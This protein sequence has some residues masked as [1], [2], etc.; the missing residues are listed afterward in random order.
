[1]HR[2]HV[3]QLAAAFSLCLSDSIDLSNLA[4]QHFHLDITD[5]LLILDAV[6]KSNGLTALCSE[7]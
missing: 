7:T 5:M 3:E 4:Q 6:A 1:M 2:L